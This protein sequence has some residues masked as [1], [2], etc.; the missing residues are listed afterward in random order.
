MTAG[1]GKTT[2]LSSIAGR[3]ES[4][5]QMHGNVLHYATENI[6]AQQQIISTKCAPVQTTEVAWLQQHD[7]FFERLT[8]EETLNFVAFLELPHLSRPERQ[9][10][11]KSCLDSLGLSSVQSRQVGSA[12]AIQATDGASLSGGERRRLSVA[13]ELVSMPNLL[14]ADEP[15]SGIDSTMSENVMSA[16]ATLVRQRQIPCFCTLHQPRS[17]IWHM[18]DSVILMAPGGRVVYIG[19]REDAL[20]Y[21]AS[22]G[23]ACPAETNPA[24]FLVDLVSIDPENATQALIDEDRIQLLAYAFSRYMKERSTVRARAQRVCSISESVYKIDR[25]KIDASQH[26]FRPI[27]R[28]GALF[29][30]SWRQNFRST[31]LNIFRLGTSMGTALLLSQI[32]PSVSKGIAQPKSVVDRVALLSFGVINM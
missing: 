7:V 27:R 17:S 28:L 3:P 15:T 29:L 2:F 16:I 10:V 4:S 31:A 25:R 18:L 1:A 19:H 26:P 13:V 20:P 5:L 22:L 32:F 24:E 21:F 6:H 23:F 8:V 30:R 12:K 9:N 14:V 11:A